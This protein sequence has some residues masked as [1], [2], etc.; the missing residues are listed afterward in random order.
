MAKMK[1]ARLFGPNDLR[2]VKTPIPE[3]GE[4]DVL[5][6]VERVGVCGTDYAIYSGEFSFVKDGSITFPKTLGHEWSATVEAAGK[7][8]T[9]F[10][11]GDRVVGDTCVGCGR[12]QFCLSGEY[13]RCREFKA[14][15]TIHDRDGAYAEYIVMPER[16]LFHLPDS[17]SID[18]GAFVEP[19]ATSLYA[20]K[21]AEVGIGDTVLV[22]G[23]GPLGILAARLSKI[24]GA[25]KVIITGRKKYKLDIALGNGAD[26]AINTN[27]QGVRDVVMEHTDNRGVDRIIETSGSTQLFAESFD[28]IRTGGTMSV[29]AF[30]EKNIEEFDID[31]FVFSNITVR[32]VAGS[33]HMYP[34]VLSLMS[35]GLLQTDQLITGRYPFEKIERALIDM[36]ERNAIRIKWI[37]DIS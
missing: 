9:N 8:V 1:T 5:C 20:V 29:V 10:K 15:G 28:S 4:N 3:V 11:P 25:A 26:I 37:V 30:Y 31:K 19:A 23:T 16:H 22:H 14:V 33:M 6:K 7:S 12:C 36:K 17:V 35:S 21:R 24:S 2:I 34:A 13:N 27:E 32:A 18:Q